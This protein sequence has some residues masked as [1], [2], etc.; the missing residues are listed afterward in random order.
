MIQQA[1]I[2]YCAACATMLN[3]RGTPMGDSF[4]YDCPRCGLLQVTGTAISMLEDLR[5]RATASKIDAV[6]HVARRWERGDKA[7]FV[8]SS[9][10][11]KWFEEA[12]LASLTEQERNLVLWLG[13]KRDSDGDPSFQHIVTEGE[14]ASIV[15][16]RSLPEAMRFIVDHA[17]SAGLVEDLDT[18]QRDKV[19]VFILRLTFEGWERFEEL[20]RTEADSRT[21]FMA[22]AFGNADLDSVY[23]D[24]FSPA[25]ADAGFKLRRLDENQGAGLIDDQLRVAIRTAKFL[26]ADLTTD[27]RGA[28]WEAGFAEGLGKPVIYVCEASVF[29]NERTR[30]HFDTNHLL[31]VPWNRADLT[32]ARRRL[33]ATIRNTFPLDANMPSR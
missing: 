10:A 12:E 31:T 14:L 6:S 19:G 30:P 16:G 2:D 20:Q 8:S 15:G 27:N 11:R 23:R 5:A 18:A 26:I 3:R 1:A 9:T 7:L 17:A 13:L 22:M 32:D 25:S 28:Y 24:C 21:A 4:L 33:T 29:N